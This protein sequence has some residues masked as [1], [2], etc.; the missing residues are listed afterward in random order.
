MAIC[1]CYF[2]SVCGWRFTHF[3]DVLFVVESLPTYLAIF[4]FASNL[5]NFQSTY[6][7]NHTVC[8]IAQLARY[9]ELCVWVL[10]FFGYFIHEV[11]HG[12]SFCFIFTSC[13]CLACH[14]QRVELPQT[15]NAIQVNPNHNTNTIKNNANIN[16]TPIDSHLLY[17]HIHHATT[18]GISVSSTYTLPIRWGRKGLFKLWI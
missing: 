15:P 16:M 12:N 13:V 2:V 7:A 11:S 10:S 5:Y 14:L 4:I 8:I 1:G 3:S 17:I 6:L 18:T 9:P